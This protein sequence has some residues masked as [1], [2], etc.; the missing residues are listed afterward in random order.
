MLLTNVWP[1]SV[2]RILG[3]SA[4]VGNEN[5]KME[6]KKQNQLDQITT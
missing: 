2:G 4:V 6:M 5:D 1:R 3:R